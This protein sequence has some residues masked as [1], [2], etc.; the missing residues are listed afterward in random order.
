MTEFSIY[1]VSLWLG[2][3]I[4]IGATLWVSLLNPQNL[5]SRQALAR[6]PQWGV[7]LG[8]LCLLWCI[9]HAQPIVWDWMRPW[10]LP[11]AIAFAGIG[12]F[13]L[14]YLFARALGGLLILSAYYYLHA[15]FTFHTPASQLFAVMCWSF[16]IGG[17]FLA[18]KPY[19]LR[20]LIR[21]MAVDWRWKVALQLF[22]AVFALYC[23]TVGIVHAVS[24]RLS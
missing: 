8:L 22:L 20:D 3:L 17:L 19:L 14:D 13:F 16:G 23:L 12:Y 15:S 2:A 18:A 6:N 1:V 11:L 9:P 21:Q 7:I 10:L 4:T 24:G 5:P